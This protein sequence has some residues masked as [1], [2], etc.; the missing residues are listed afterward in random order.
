MKVPEILT[1]SRSIA[2]AYEAACQPLCC[3][4]QIPQ[5]AFDILMFLSNN[6][7]YHTARDIVQ[8]RNIRA[9][10]VSFHVEKL[11]KEGFLERRSLPDDRRKI[12]LSLT[13]RADEIAAE[14]KKIQRG[15]FESITK[16]VTESAMQI[17]CETFEII[18]GNAAAMLQTGGTLK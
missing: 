2:C 4:Y 7:Q 17:T 1:F 9:N 11:V 14:G 15:F 18:G 8:I 3:K 10:L 12:M 6:P 5:T 16:G 13:P